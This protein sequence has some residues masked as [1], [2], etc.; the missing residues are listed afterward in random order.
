MNNVRYMNDPILLDEPHELR[1]ALAALFESTGIRGECLSR[2]SNDARTWPVVEL[3]AGNVRLRFRPLFKVVDRFHGLERIKAGEGSYAEQLLLVAPYISREAAAHCRKIGMSFIDLAGNAYL[4]GP[5]LHV[6]VSG[7]QR[8]EGERYARQ[9]QAL[10]ESGLRIAYALLTQPD[11][12]GA[13]YRTIAGSANVALGAVGKAL[14]DLASRGLISPESAQPRR[15][16]DR[17]KL[18]DEWV[19]HYPVRLRPKLNAQRFS[20]AD[21]TSIDRLQASIDP[22]SYG[23]EWGGEIAADKLTHHL[24]PERLA[25]YFHGPRNA[26]I[27]EYRLRPNSYGNIELLDAFWNQDAIAH[28]DTVNPLVVYADLMAAGDG[29]LY[30]IASLIRDQYLA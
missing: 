3:V 11:L 15:L 13:T 22:K 7:L 28:P 4:F 29:R 24:L 5:G 18:I 26:F 30:E 27:K 12:C 10:T 17:E 21:D 1:M 14:G 20:S 19:I 6:F 16:L 8:K 25:L 23:A 9:Y 2:N